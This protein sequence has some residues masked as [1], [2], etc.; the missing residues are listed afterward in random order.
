MTTACHFCGEQWMPGVSENPVHSFSTALQEMEEQQHDR[1]I[2]GDE[3]YL[4]RK[5][6]LVNRRDRSKEELSA[7][8]IWARDIR[9]VQGA[10]VRCVQRVQRRV[11]GNEEI[12]AMTDPLYSSVPQ[13]AVDVIIGTGW[14]LEK[15]QTPYRGQHEPDDD[16]ALREHRRVKQLANS[17]EVR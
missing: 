13:I 17:Q 4:E 16:H 14:H 15:Q 2:A 7:C 1:H 6:R 8:W 12:R 10:C 3:R 5:E 9:I 11:A